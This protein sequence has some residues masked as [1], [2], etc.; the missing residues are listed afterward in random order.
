MS[1]PSGVCVYYGNDGHRMDNDIEKMIERVLPDQ[2]TRPFNLERLDGSEVSAAQVLVMARSLPFMA[3][4]R[5][6]VVREPAFFAAGARKKGLI[7]AEEEEE[8]L[9]FC[10]SP[11]PEALLIFRY[12]TEEAPGAY[13]KKIIAAT[14]AVH[15][16]QP[17]GREVAPWLRAEAKKMGKSFT[18]QAMAMLE[19]LA[20]QDGTLVLANELEKLSLYLKESEDLL[21]T[22]EAVAAIVTPTPS[23]TIFNLL[24]A[25]VAGKSRE[26]I[27]A[28]RDC[29]YLGTKSPQVLRQL[30]DTA[31]RLLLVQSMMA[32]G[33]GLGAI[34]ATLKRHEFYVKKL[35]GQARPIPTEALS[36]MFLYLVACDVKSKSTAGLEMDAFVEEVI[37][38]CC[39]TM[40]VYARQSR[41]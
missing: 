2:G 14:D 11:N 4:R 41:Y 33:Q 10:H 31:K 1:L 21:I 24:D 3:K 8:L 7:S 13:F 19:E 6:V 40:A 37:I 22:E 38:N 36:K 30:V 12:T 25:V 9:N 26:A 15:C 20:P 35:M 34:K 28:Y 29:L 16:V 23:R 17:K 32:E 5:V 18:P 27:Q 39:A